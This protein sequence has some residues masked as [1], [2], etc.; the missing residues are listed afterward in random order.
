MMGS[1]AAAHAQG[2]SNTITHIAMA[3]RSLS[4]DNYA[5]ENANL[6][7]DHAFAA[8]ELRRDRVEL[9]RDPGSG[10]S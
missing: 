3:F 10:I 5:F 2:S 7:G 6:F 4:T 8:W 9:R 1:P